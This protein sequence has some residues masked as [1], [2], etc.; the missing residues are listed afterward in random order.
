MW[1]F[2]LFVPSLEKEQFLLLCYEK[3]QVCRLNSYCVI[4]EQ[5]MF[6]ILCLESVNQN[7]VYH[8]HSKVASL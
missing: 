4:L 6:V 3:W 5:Y 8:Q 7:L 1:L 2:K